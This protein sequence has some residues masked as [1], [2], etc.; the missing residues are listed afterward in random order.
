[1]IVSRMSKQQLVVLITFLIAALAFYLFV[2]KEYEIML[3][4]PANGTNT[5]EGQS[6]QG[7][8]QDDNDNKHNENQ[9]ESADNQQ[10]GSQNTPSEPLWGIDSV[11]VISEEFYNCIQENFGEPSVFGRYLKDKDGVS[12]G[13]A[14]DEITLIHSKGLYMLPIYN[15]FENATT[16]ERGVKEA[17]QAIQFANDSGVPEGVAIFADIEPIYPVDS[18]FIQGW[19]ETMMKSEYESGI[20]GVFSKDSD[21]TAA[22]NKAAAE[23]EEIRTHTIIWS[24]Y[25]QKGITKKEE[26]PQYQPEAPE[27]SLN[28]GWQYGLDAEKCNIDTNLFKGEMVQFLWGPAGQ[29]SKKG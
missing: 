6:Q 25:P 7:C 5:N 4:S 3:V 21:L 23:N 27:N 17:Q 22:F 9:N 12:S 13:I 11:D 10:D 28:Y 19:H 24:S 26:A 29:P 1:M 15:H 16:Y 14:K 18:A 20:Y 2:I 8:S